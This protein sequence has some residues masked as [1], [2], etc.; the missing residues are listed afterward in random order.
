MSMLSEV[1]KSHRGAKSKPKSK[2]KG[3][4]KQVSI[5]PVMGGGHVVATEHEPDPNDPNEMY[6]PPETQTFPNHSAM[7]SHVHQQTGGSPASNPYTQD[8]NA[9]PTNSNNKGA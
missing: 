2:G 5:R 1:A 4:V 7:M 3:A 9:T 6:E 8:P